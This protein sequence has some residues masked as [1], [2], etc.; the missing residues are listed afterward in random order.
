MPVAKQTYTVTAPWSNADL[1][2]GLRNAFNGAGLMPTSTWHDSFANGGIENRVLEVVYDPA[3]TYGKTYYWFKFSTQIYIHVASAWDVSTHKPNGTQYVDFYTDATNTINNACYLTSGFNSNTTVTITRWTSEL[4]PLFTWFLI[5]CGTASLNFHLSLAAPSP[6]IDLAKVFYTSIMWA[7]TFTSSST[8][9]IGFSLFP[10]V[11]RRSYLGAGLR[12]D[13][14]TFEFGAGGIYTAFKELPLQRSYHFP[15]NS[16]S[17]GP[18]SISLYNGPLLPYGFQ[19][20]NS[21]FTADATPI[22]SKL[23]ISYYSGSAVLPEDFGIAGHYASNTMSPF[24]QFV[25][26]PGSDVWDIIA[27]TNN[28]AANNGMVSPLLVAKVV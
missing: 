22:I 19:N 8:G 10:P 1:A 2:D 27:V 28:L 14:G 26:A 20:A 7:R 18:F 24:D 21:A 16:S 9:G 4:N 17:S 23:E 25:V 11:A 5:R 3:K 13:T 15:G 6:W 12:L